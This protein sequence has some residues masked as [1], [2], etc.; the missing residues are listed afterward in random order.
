MKR[1][2]DYKFYKWIVYITLF[3]TCIPGSPVWAVSNA[4]VG[5]HGAPFLKISSAARQ[6]G[7]GDAF[8]AM[9]DDINLLK[10]N[11][12]GLGQLSNEMLAINFHNWIDDTQ[13]GSF[14]L[15][16]PNRYG[17]VGMDFTYFN[18]G[19]L[20]ALDVNFNQTGKTF[21]AS[22]VMA[23]LAFGTR[24]GFRDYVFG[25]GMGMKYLRQELAGEEASAFAF[26]IGAHLPL[27]GFQFGAT[28][29]NIGLTKLQFQDMKSP[30]PTTFRFGSATT[31]GRLETMALNVDADVAWIPKEKMRFYLGNELILSNLLYLRAGY[32]F[33]QTAAS[34][35]SAGFGLNIPMDWLANAETRFDYA[36]SRL[37][38]ME[39]DVHRFSLLMNFGVKKDNNYDEMLQQELDAARRSRI[40]LQ[41]MEDEMARRLAKAKEIAAESGGK[42]E[43]E[44]KAGNQILVRMRI[45]FDF[46]KY[47]IRPQDEATVDQVGEILST[48]NDSKVHVTGHTDS[49]GTDWYNIRLSQKRI[50]SVISYLKDH[51]GFRDEK[52]YLPI[53]YGELRPIADNG[54]EEGRAL[55][56]RVEFLLFSQDS[57][58]E[59]PDGS[60]FSTVKMVNDQVVQLVF[61]G[62]V[63]FTSR[64]LNSPE[65]LIIDVPN[66]Y[67][68][69][70]VKEVALNR[71]P[72][73]RARMGFHREKV[74]FT[75]IV[76]DLSHPIQ[77]D[78]QALENYIFVKVK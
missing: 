32:Q 55:N 77:A 4:G 66:V 30:L 29:Q 33:H 56:R 57:K 5:Y 35:F 11:V 61:N 6:V 46:D 7:M 75:R 31:L 18:E 3:L 21:S 69:S 50:E 65:R 34:P 43:V 49:V 59:L 42:I 41:Q 51:R 78:I 9:A 13:Q 37:N 20:E 64:T 12:G 23:T 15:A 62:K 72:F 71:G 19:S 40:A 8:T 2:P 67:M 25:V 17:V 39:T 60:A 26:D 68:L 74:P 47:N 70:D 44:E 16:F 54:T 24:L 73:I 63:E 36:Y 14:A 76:L 22:D 58:P 48:Y 38:A 53:G 28:I 1:F 10:Y 27:Y 45:N 52:F